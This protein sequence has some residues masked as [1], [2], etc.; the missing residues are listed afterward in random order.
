M[1]N[2]L[3]LP[4]QENNQREITEQ[5]TNSC[6]VLEAA[7]GEGSQRVNGDSR[8]QLTSWWES[9]K[10]CRSPGCRSLSTFWILAYSAVSIQQSSVQMS[11]IKHSHIFPRQKFFVCL[12]LNFFLITV[13]SGY[14]LVTVPRKKNIFSLVVFFYNQRRL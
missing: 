11:E 10:H 6:T 2:T 3:R 12:F 7:G 14:I 13:S 8:P 4:I 9:L 1:E 5:L